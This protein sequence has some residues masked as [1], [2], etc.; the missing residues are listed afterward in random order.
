VL[1]CTDARMQEVYTAAYAHDGHDWEEIGAPA[2]LPPEL[3]QVP[4]AAVWDV[5]NGFAAYP[6]LA[7]GCR[8]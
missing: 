4:E 3:V 7:S 8:S 1:V 2:V 5:G 6:Q